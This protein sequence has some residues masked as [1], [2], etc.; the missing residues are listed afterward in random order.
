MCG[1]GDYRRFAEGTLSRFSGGGSGRGQT[2]TRSPPNR[3][4][5]YSAASCI[6]ARKSLVACSMRRAMSAMPAAE[7]AVRGAPRA[8]SVASMAVRLVRSARPVRRPAVSPASGRSSALV[9]LAIAIL[10][11][12]DRYRDAAT[13]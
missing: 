7:V 4:N 5:C 3:N 11:A 8:R 1:G 12:D 13:L 6:A 2:P 10:A 9:V